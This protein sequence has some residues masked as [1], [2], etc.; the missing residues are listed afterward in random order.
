[1]NHSHDLRA[2]F[3]AA[4]LYGVALALGQPRVRWGDREIRRSGHAGAPNEYRLTALFGFPPVSRKV[5]N[6]KNAIKSLNFSLR[7]FLRS[8][9]AFS[10]NESTQKIF[11]PAL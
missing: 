11:Y 5:T 7:N 1:M 6:N 3:A 10:N 4:T 2:F 8:C 9:G